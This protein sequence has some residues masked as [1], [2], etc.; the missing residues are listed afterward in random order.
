MLT[1]FS[2]KAVIGDADFMFEM[3]KTEFEDWRCQ[4][5]TSNRIPIEFGY[6]KG[7]Y[8]ISVEVALAAGR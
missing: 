1:H 3:T 2:L 5:G 8:L 7:C 4:F 6:Q